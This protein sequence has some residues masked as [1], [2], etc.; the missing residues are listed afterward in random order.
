MTTLLKNNWYL[1]IN[2]KKIPASV[3][4]DITI[5]AFKADLIDNPYFA[6]NYKKAEWI[7]RSDFVYEN[8]IDIT[9]AM[10]SFDVIDLV[11]K[12]IDLYSDI[13]INGHLLGSTK[14]LLNIT[15]TI[16]LQFI[17]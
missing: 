11:F 4:G 17:K 3:P 10:L 13:Y 1:T 2:D 8:E 9:E 6:K 16:I 12:G 7:Q 5:D 15:I 14:F